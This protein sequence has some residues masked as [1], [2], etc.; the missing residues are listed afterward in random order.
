MFEV[1]GKPVRDREERL[2][3][4]FLQP[5]ADAR[6]QE[7]DI[8]AA[9][10]RYNIGGVNRTVNLPVLALAVLEAKNRPWFSFKVARR[11]RATWRLRYS[12]DAR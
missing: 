6:R 12:S 11:G 4:L 2:T 9:S 8:A 7:L 10:A 5:S 3:R 1:D